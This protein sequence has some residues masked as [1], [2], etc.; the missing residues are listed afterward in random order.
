LLSGIGKPYDAQTGEGVVGRNYAYQ[1]VGGQPPSSTRRRSINPFMA[2]RA[3]SVID[4]FNGGALDIGKAGY[5]GGGAGELLVDGGRP[6]QFH[7]VP[8]GTPRGAATGSVRVVKHY[9]HTAIV[10]HQ[11]DAQE[12]EART[13]RAPRCAGFSATGATSGAGARSLKFCRGC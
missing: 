8:H 5:I 9:N 10:G 1:S 13:I 4:D 11:E 12:R 3:E 7:P 2:P 6:I